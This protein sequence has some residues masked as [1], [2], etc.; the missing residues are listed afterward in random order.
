MIKSAISGISAA[1]DVE[2]VVTK[3]RKQA[4]KTVDRFIL[5]YGLRIPHGICVKL[6]GKFSRFQASPASTHALLWQCI[7]ARPR[8]RMARG[9]PVKPRLRPPL[10]RIDGFPVP[11]VGQPPVN[12]SH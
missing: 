2:N 11:K 6:C 8:S 9:R 10:S 7:E 5:N 4:P 3:A 1:R 12:F